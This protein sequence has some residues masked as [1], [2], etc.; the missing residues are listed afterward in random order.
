[1][2][3]SS[4]K[5]L[6]IQGCRTYKTQFSAGGSNEKLY[7]HFGKPFSQCLV[8]LNINLPYDTGIPLLDIHTR[9]MVIKRTV[10][11]CV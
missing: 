5:K 4:C 9:E 10:S 2:Y 7:R 11:E 3:I 1:M 8:K 6:N